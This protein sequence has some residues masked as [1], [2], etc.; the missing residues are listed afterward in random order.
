MQKLSDDLQAAAAA[1]PMYPLS[2]KV[3]GVYIPAK[4]A[5]RV[6]DFQVA[7][8]LKPETQAMMQGI[9]GMDTEL[10]IDYG[11]D[12]DKLDPGTKKAVTFGKYYVR[13]SSSNLDGYIYRRMIE[14]SEG[15]PGIRAYERAMYLHGLAGFLDGAH[16]PL[17]VE[18][19]F[20]DVLFLGNDNGMRGETGDAM[21]RALDANENLDHARGPVVVLFYAFEQKAS[22]P[23]TDD[24]KKYF[25][26]T[27]EMVR[28]CIDTLFSAV[29]SEME[30]RV[31]HMQ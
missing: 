27:D 28:P 14:L 24:H 20:M 1:Q 31:K 11:P 7:P 29:S 12:Y 30:R 6:M 26:V 19:I 5:W 2:G 25:S 4:G 13:R 3:G 17:D 8:D 21:F 22:M 10:D 16:P 18:D 23:F 15:E 9:E